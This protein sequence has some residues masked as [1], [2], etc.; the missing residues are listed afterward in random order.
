MNIEPLKLNSKGAVVK[1]LQQKLQAL[2]FAPGKPDGFFGAGTE[3]AVINF[4]LSEG[5]YADGVAGPNTIKKLGL[6]LNMKFPDDTTYLTDQIVVQMTGASFNNVRVYLPAIK[7]AMKEF[8]IADRL[9]LLSAIASISAE[10][11]AFVPI[12][13]GISRYN[14]SPG[15]HPFNLY[16]NRN[17]LGNKGVPDGDK[18]KGRGFIQLTGRANYTKYSKQ[19]GLGTLLVTN[20]EKANDPT[21]AARILAAF[22]ADKQNSIR[23]ALAELDYKTARKAV[24]GGSHGLDRFTIAF[25][26]GD[27]LLNV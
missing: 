21:I 10:T 1:K 22:L 24:N 12:N 26:K 25:E 13:E 9:M 17:D 27:E 4:Q 7:T 8:Q 18:F 6:K 14:T 5:L 20:P 2:G 3:A 23:A 19:L 11:S 16:D 15:G